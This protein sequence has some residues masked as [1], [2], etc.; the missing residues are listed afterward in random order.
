MNVGKGPK[1][2][3]KF[4]VQYYDD[5]EETF[6]CNLYE[7]FKNDEV[8]LIEVI[9]EDFIEVSIKHLYSDQVTG[10][11]TWWS[12]EVR[13][14][15][16]ESEDLN[17]PEFFVVYENVLQDDE[18][19]EEDLGNEPEYYLIPLLHDYLNGWVRFV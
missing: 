12:A 7:D 15:D 14:V 3:P 18:G 13:D 19:N 11:E 16:D 5:S 9:P 10:E 2:N 8:R 1:T 4:L 6:Y 17:N